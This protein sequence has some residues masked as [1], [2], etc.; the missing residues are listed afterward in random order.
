[1]PAARRRLGAA[2]STRPRWLKIS[3]SSPLSAGW[4]FRVHRPYRTAATLLSRRLRID[5]TERRKPGPP[6]LNIGPGED[7]NT[8]DYGGPSSQPR[9]ARTE[10]ALDLGLRLNSPLSV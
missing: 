10:A 1:M 2:I 9:S 4:L 6:P 8:N 5:G 7:R 3:A